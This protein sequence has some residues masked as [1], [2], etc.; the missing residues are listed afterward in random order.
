[1]EDGGW[2]LGVT[3]IADVSFDFTSAKSHE[4]VFELPRLDIFRNISNK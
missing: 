3:Y 1:M 2:G 4:F